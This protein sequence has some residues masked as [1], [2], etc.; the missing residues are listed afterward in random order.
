VKLKLQN[1]AEIWINTAFL[2]KIPMLEFA[3]N[4]CR[5]PD[6]LNA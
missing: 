6:M 5:K 3:P 4:G 1:K 2:A